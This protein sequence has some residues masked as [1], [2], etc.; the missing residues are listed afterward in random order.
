[1]SLACNLAR[2]PEE[3]SSAFVGKRVARH[4]RFH[5]P[6][7]AG[8]SPARGYSAF[9]VSRLFDLLTGDEVKTLTCHSILF[10]TIPTSLSTS[11][12]LVPRYDLVAASSANR[13][14]DVEMTG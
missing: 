9:A 8:P 3:T 10:Q 1:M 2:Y 6:G 7:R 5:Q 13:F 11:L 4:Q 14:G 12:T